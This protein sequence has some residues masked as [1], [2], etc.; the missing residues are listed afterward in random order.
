MGTFSH[1]K[2]YERW[3]GRWSA[4][5]APGFVAFSGLAA[6]GRLLDVGAGTGV[7]CAALSRAFPAA[8]IV[9]LEPAPDYVE[10]AR[11]KLA[12]PRLRFEQGGAE[13]IPYGDGA[14]DACLALLI[15]QELEDAGLAVAEMARV[16]RPGGLLA[17]CQWDFA[18]GLPMIDRFWSALAELRSPDEAEKEQAART[19]LGFSDAE[20]LAGLWTKAG[21]SDVETAELE[22]EM[23]FASFADYW[24]P[25]LGGATATSSYAATLPEAE[26]AALASR[27]RERLLGA[28][29]DRAFSLPT[30][31]WAVRGRVP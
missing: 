26:Q 3:M 2:A 14:F 19:P 6:P 28:G 30:R 23:T 4:K 29:P 21:L 27:L 11:S 31:A 22:T 20:I 9:G 10:H 18:E 5:L 1:A 24:D 8:E 13:A 25:F 17:A 16:T 12:G 7:L 15:L